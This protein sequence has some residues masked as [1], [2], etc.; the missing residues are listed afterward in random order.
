LEQQKERQDAK[1]PPRTRGLMYQHIS[2][3]IS[4]NL[5]IY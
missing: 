5:T 1:V 3:F 2:A 4:C